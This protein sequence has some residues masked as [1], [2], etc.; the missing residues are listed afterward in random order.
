LKILKKADDIKLNNK[1]NEIQEENDLNKKVFIKIY[2]FQDMRFYS[3][4]EN[5]GI[6]DE[7]NIQKMTN[8]ERVFTNEKDIDQ[9]N[10]R[11]KRINNPKSRNTRKLDDIEELKGKT[12]ELD[13]TNKNNNVDEFTR[14]LDIANKN[15][16]NK[17]A[18][19]KN[20]NENQIDK[21]YNHNYEIEAAIISEQQRE[22]ND[23]S[24]LGNDNQ[25]T[26][27]NLM[28]RKNKTQLDTNND[29][30]EANNE[31]ALED[32]DVNINFDKD[33]DK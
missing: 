23:N 27:Y 15:N 8:N 14:S 9:S 4:S 26:F 21:E 1:V 32:D 2:L 6:L 13:N 22:E 28:R 12:D 30:S 7:K 19:G 20:N 18:V 17:L 11:K 31:K 5:T 16:I 10:T 29:L 3:E 24:N 25:V 33:F